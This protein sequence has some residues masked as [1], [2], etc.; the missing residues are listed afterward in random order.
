V[1]EGRCPGLLD[2]AGATAFVA[3]DAGVLL[4]SFAISFLTAGVVD[5]ADAAFLTAA[6]LLE[7][8]ASDCLFAAVVL[9]VDATGFAVDVVEV[10]DLVALED[11]ASD[12]LAVDDA[13]FFTGA[14]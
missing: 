12:C 11:G 10:V 13:G 1:L 7:D 9:D 6:V 2:M 14:A 3:G 8:G 4:A 5:E